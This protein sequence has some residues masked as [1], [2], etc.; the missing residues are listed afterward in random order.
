VFCW[1][2][3]T[4]LLVWTVCSAGVDRVAFAQA[5]RA[6]VMGELDAARNRTRPLGYMS[7]QGKRISRFFTFVGRRGAHKVT[8]ASG[9]GVSSGGGRGGGRGDDVGAVKASGTP[10]VS[11]ASTRPRALKNKSIVTR[12][13][14]RAQPDLESGKAKT[15]P[16]S[17][18]ATR[19]RIPDLRASARGTTDHG[20][21]T[22]R[23][24]AVGVGGATVE[25]RGERVQAGDN[26]VLQADACAQ[27]GDRA[28]DSE[29]LIRGR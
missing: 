9:G 5:A 28:D 12:A 18:W 11:T 10:S 22:P 17:S 13:Y 14:S 3:A 7:V 27:G 4:V 20:G 15:T 29:P 25:E 19:V 21:I 2:S 26:R 16:A 8:P 6:Q 24:G 1:Y 23:D